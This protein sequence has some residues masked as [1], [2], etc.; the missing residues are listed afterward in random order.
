M[1]RIAMRY[2]KLRHHGAMFMSLLGHHSRTCASVA[3]RPL[4]RCSVRYLEEPVGS[5]QS[6][7]AG[8]AIGST[9]YGPDPWKLL[10]QFRL[11]SPDDHLL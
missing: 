9:V 11:I 5:I 1:S 7:G 10:V 4:Q 2:Q 3:K 6:W 8:Y